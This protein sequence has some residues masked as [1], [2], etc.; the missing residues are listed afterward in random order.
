MSLTEPRRALL[1]F[2]LAHAFIFC[3]FFIPAQTV[4][5]DPGALER[6]MALKILD[7]QVPFRD[8]P[9]EYPP[10]ALLAFLLPAL[11]AKTQ[12]AYNIA[13]YSEILIFDIV[14]M[15]AMVGIARRLE[16][17]IWKTLGIYTLLLLAVGPLVIIRFD[18]LPAMLVAVSLQAF[19][20]GKYRAAWALLAFGVSAKLYPILLTPLFAF[21]HLA[22]RQYRALVSGVITFIAAAL[23]VFVPL[24]LLHADELWSSLG[25]YHLGR[26]LHSESTYGSFLLLLKAIGIYEVEAGLSF[27]SWNLISPLADRLAGI[28][29]YISA[30]LLLITCGW[31]AGMFRKR[32]GSPEKSKDLRLLQFT[33]LAL[34]VF[35]VTNKVLSAQYLIWLCPLL[36]LIARSG[37]DILW[38]LFIAAAVITQWIFPYA[39]YDFEQFKPYALVLMFLRNFL[40]LAVAVLTVVFIYRN[41]RQTDWR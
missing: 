38:I 28:S 22:R 5:F 12:V 9:S 35:I 27:G 14:V 13:F 23:L 1:L 11:V 34:L 36:A 31:F 40:L 25:G 4:Y 18:L 15:W 10:L 2:S 29:F 20:A 37:E 16:I 41:N 30:G 8:F 19:F 26:G 24:L 7:G 17:P 3:L 21:Y 32:P 6:F 39:Y 33:F